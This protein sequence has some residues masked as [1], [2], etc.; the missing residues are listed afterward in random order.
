MAQERDVGGP[1]GPGG[2]RGRHRTPVHRHQQGGKEREHG[3]EG[4][5]DGD[6]GDEAELLDAAE[7]GE[8]Q[9]TER[10]GGSEGPEQDPGTGAR[11][12]RVESLLRCAT[13]PELLLVTEEEIDPVVD[14]DADQEGYE[15]H[16]E[17]GQVPHGGRDD[18][19]RPGETREQDGRH[20]EGRHGTPHHE[21][22]GADRQGHGEQCRHRAVAE[23]GQHLVVRQRGRPGG[24]GG[25]VGVRR[26]Q[27]PDGAA[28]CRDE[29]LVVGEVG[30][31]P[32]WLD[33]QEEQPVVSG[34]EVPRALVLGRAGE[35]AGPRRG[36]DTDALD[37]LGDHAEQGVDEPG[38]DLLR[39][40]AIET[41]IDEAEGQAARDLVADG[42]QEL[43]QRGPRGVPLD[44]G[45]VQ[46]DL[47]G[48]IVELRR[49][50]V[51]QGLSGEQVGVDAIRNSAGSGQPLDLG[52]E[53]VGVD[54]RP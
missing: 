35:D 51:E 34:E 48:E 10:P 36:P 23:R 21:E 30:G 52:G 14:A 24:A 46:P 9:D 43:G 3:D 6:A 38:I 54:L 2:R 33:E 16:R 47:V 49:G 13:E 26:P 17:D 11:R 7:L 50:Q 53:P 20:D 8:H 1:A 32:S 4:H 42:V 39:P 40:A 27:R 37:P 44:E 25:D 12:G 19:E 5:Q 41:E 15:H 29:A 31:L 45:P 18:A 28:D 22:E